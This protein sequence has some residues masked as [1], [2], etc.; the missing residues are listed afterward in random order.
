MINRKHLVRHLKWLK[1][2]ILFL[3]Y[4]YETGRFLKK[5]TLLTYISKC[6]GWVGF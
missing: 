5:S 4:K 3:L 6:G 2:I 1:L